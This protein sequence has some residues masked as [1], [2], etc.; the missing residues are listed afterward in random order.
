MC[1]EKT[2]MVYIH[3]PFCASRC[4]YCDF[5]STT[6]TQELKG[7]YIQT[8]C[9]EV[10]NRRH[11]LNNAPLQSVYIGGGTPSQ[12]EV[13]QL[14]QL[15]GTVHDAFELSNNAEITIEANPDD[16]SADF[17]KG[18]KALGVNRMSLGVQSFDDAI[19]RIINRRHSAREACQ[20]VDTIY[21]CGIEN[22]SI[23]LIYGLPTQ[24]ISQFGSDLKC[25]FQL[26]IKHLSSYAL[27]VEEGTALDSMIRKGELCPTDESLYIEA[28]N[29]LMEQCNEH[30]F[31]HYEISNFAQ[32]GFASRH[33][34]G[35]WHGLPYLGIGPGAHS[36]DG[37][38]TRRYNLPNLRTYAEAKNGDVAHETEVLTDTE[39]FDEL[40]FTSLRTR[41]GLDI[42]VV[43]ARFS[44]EWL[45][46]MLEDA[47]PHITAGRILLA[48]NKLVLT[49]KGIM[50][51]NDV[52]SDLMRAD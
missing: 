12:L 15:L 19:L 44:M 35:Y 45:Y 16:V 50:T 1:V 38:R 41:D 22:I 29:L 27:S 42:D 36:F 5:Y 30:G 34:S 32:R 17:V 4:I 24:T 28:Y 7:H 46:Q 13:K 51:S 23:D 20:A 21:N 3:A 9:E 25:A 43:K 18:I 40:L 39:A 31:E 33:N 6:H 10:I 49:Q 2:N 11:E 8:A 47:Q 52:I 48:D 26:P 37:K 14:A